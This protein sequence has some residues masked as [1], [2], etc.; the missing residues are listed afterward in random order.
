MFSPI[1]I[2]APADYLSVNKTYTIP[3]GG[4]QLFV[5]IVI[6]ADSG[7]ESQEDFTAIISSASINAVILEPVT[8]VTIIDGDGNVNIKCVIISIISS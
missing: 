7:T 5:P 4:T 8:T 3:A 1:H 6:Q 2:I